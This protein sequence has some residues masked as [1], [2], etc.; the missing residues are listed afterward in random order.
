MN[1]E[2]IIRTYFEADRTAVRERYDAAFPGMPPAAFRHPADVMV[3][4]SGRASAEKLHGTELTEA[5]KRDVASGRW[6]PADALKLIGESGDPNSY[7]D[8][9]EDLAYSLGMTAEIQEATVA[10]MRTMDWIDQT[11]LIHH[12]RMLAHS[13]IVPYCAEG[14]MLLLKFGSASRILHNISSSFFFPLETEIPYPRY[15]K[16]LHAL[17]IQPEVSEANSVI[18][19]AWAISDAILAFTE[20]H[21]LEYWQ[22][23][24][25]INDLGPRLL[26]ED[27]PFPTDLGPRVWLAAA[28]PENFDEV[29]S[30][31]S[32]DRVIWSANEKAKYGDLVLMYCTAPRSSL[33]AIYRCMTDAYRDPLNRD[34][35]GVWAEIGEK[36]PIPPLT[37]REMREDSVLRNWGMVKMQ[38]QGL[39]KHAVPHDSWSRLLELIEERDAEAGARVRAYAGSATG[40]RQL[41]FAPGEV[42]EQA[43]EDST[44]IPLLGRLGWKLGRDLERQ[45]EMAI[46]IGSG[47]PILAR[48]D[49]VG[50]RS[51]LGSEV[52]IVIE[53]KRS[54]RNSAELEQAMLQAESYAGKLRCTRFAVAAPQGIWV[55][56]MSFPSQSR[57]L[58]DQPVPLEA[59]TVGRLRELLGRRN[60]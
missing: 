39:M 46:K 34:W 36:L 49:V 14:L 24:A 22:T 5:R 38:F 47:R 8:L 35:T 43:F 7:R 37:F 9:M 60:G 11:A 3:K 44:L 56:E 26:P 1:V 41:T 55:Y 6:R 28:G 27:S 45:V 42:S 17:G 18:Q 31:T 58:T 25:L 21:K 23:W 4:M 52:E 33:V 32:T 10:S 20:Q 15:D 30:H 53:S 50:Y 51:T 29:D 57:S 12:L 16:T 13:A 2:A 48:A 40:V 19:N 59:K 54:I